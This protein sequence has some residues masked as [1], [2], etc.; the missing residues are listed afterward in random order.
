MDRP[1]SAPPRPEARDDTGRRLVREPEDRLI[2][3]V[4]AGLADHLG[5][6]VSLVR[7]AAVLLTLL[8]PAPV[9]AYVVAAAV[10]PERAPDQP[11]RRAPARDVPSAALLGV[12]AIVVALALLGDHRWWFDPFPAGVLLVGVGVWMVVQA[13]GDRRVPPPAGHTGDAPTGNP[14]DQASVTVS[15]LSD[16]ERDRSTTVG[17]GSSEGAIRTDGGPPGE[18]SPPASPRWS[19]GAPATAEAP[20][21]PAR[22]WSGPSAVA[23]AL[24]LVGTGVL[25][26]IDA[27]D[28]ADVSREAAL[29]WGLVG[30]GA[31]LVVGAWYGGAW[32]LLPVAVVLALV[33]AAGEVLG[34][35]LDAGTG[36]RR[37]VI[38]TADQL[39]ERHELLAGR[40]E[41][42]LRDAPLS[43][44]RVQELQA[45][46]GAG[47]L[48]V[49]VPRDADVE[50]RARTR[51][52]AVLAE[53][54]TRIDNRV[55]NGAFVDQRFTLDAPGAGPRLEL[56]LQVGLGKIEVDRG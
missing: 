24:L 8:T 20:A 14:D 22:R 54:G 52:G 11:R 55:E 29:G 27:L 21:R 48:R 9:V 44:T 7:L 47:H 32:P 17:Y 28:V 53:R 39:D 45:A 33:L 51:V 13:R 18:T 3:G 50:V 31:A 37:V 6:D 43:R 4:C 46:V 38:E 26:L 34:V 40:L 2:A 35:P 49:V 1:S 19:T 30:I 5:L 36:E 56:D 10:L 23:G 25:W 12:L 41:L 16:A 42:D 15:Q